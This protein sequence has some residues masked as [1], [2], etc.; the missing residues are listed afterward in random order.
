[1]GEGAVVALQSFGALLRLCGL[2]VEQPRSAVALRPYAFSCVTHRTYSSILLKKAN[3]SCSRT[4]T[5]V[6]EYSSMRGGG[7][8][9]PDNRASRCR[10]LL[11]MHKKSAC[12]VLVLVRY[13][14]GQCG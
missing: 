6:L 3:L 11:G 9:F 1:M 12:L 8:P 4:S 10:K 13:D 14:T 2:K 5:G 7:L